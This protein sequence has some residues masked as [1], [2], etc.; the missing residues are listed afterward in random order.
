MKDLSD[1]VNGKL[2]GNETKTPTVGGPP[3]G[4]SLGEG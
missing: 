1:A 2:K 3:I 4:S